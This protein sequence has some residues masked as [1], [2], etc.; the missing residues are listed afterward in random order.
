MN[1]NFAKVLNSRFDELNDLSVIKQR[2]TKIPPSP[3]SLMN[4][5]SDMI[6]NQITHLLNELYIPT[7]ADLKIL[8]Q[9]IGDMRA[10]CKSVYQTEQQ[11]LSHIYTPL[12]DFLVNWHAPICLTGPAGVGKTSMLRALKRL[13]P[14]AS[15]IE[16]GRGHDNIPTQ[17]YWHIQVQSL[18]TSTA[19]LSPFVHTQLGDNNGRPRQIVPL[20]AKIAYKSG[21]SLLVL[22]E[23]QFLT[24]S[25][26]ANTSV[27]KCLYQMAYI[28]LP[29]IFAANYSLCR[30]LQRR[31]EQDRQRLLSR[32]QILLPATPDSP[33][34]SEYLSAIQAVL[35]DSLHIDLVRERYVIYQFTAG[36]KRLTVQL[37]T[38]AYHLVWEKGLRQVTEADLRNAFDHTEYATAREQA[39]DMLSPYT[40]ANKQYECPFPLPKVTAAVLADHQKL[41]QQQLLAKKV[42]TDALPSAE[43]EALGVVKQPK[44]PKASRKRK[45][46]ADELRQAAYRRQSRRPIN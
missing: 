6:R 3:N 12:D 1:P 4:T 31:P 40:Q 10:H 43:R 14:V 39:S 2:V 21:V 36:L 13:L 23:L 7:T 20:C 22:D 46:T 34:W 35:G 11:F 18:S 24:Q 45:V 33:D 37:I 16:I 30:L 29:F 26:T 5:Q 44:A 8:H 9:L 32:P 41:L 17:S 25:S 42:Q 28:G 38:L 15:E 27:T 19:L